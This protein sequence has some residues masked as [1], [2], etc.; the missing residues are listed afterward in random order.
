MSS[1][2]GSHSH[3]ALPHPFSNTVWQRR[4]DEGKG[5]KP[6]RYIHELSSVNKSDKMSNS[7]WIVTLELMYS[8]CIKKITEV[9]QREFYLKF[10]RLFYIMA[11]SQIDMCTVGW[12]FELD[13]QRKEHAGELL[14]IKP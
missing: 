6:W 4:E 12:L 14:I 2:H 11:V 8:M 1:Q 5:G 13:V 9:I 3:L 10:K 7:A